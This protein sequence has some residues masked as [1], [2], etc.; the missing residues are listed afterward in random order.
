MRDNDGAGVLTWEV[1]S[2][3][4]Q[5]VYLSNGIINAKNALKI[6]LSLCNK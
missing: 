5:D 1:I 4:V 3:G 6:K 2:Q